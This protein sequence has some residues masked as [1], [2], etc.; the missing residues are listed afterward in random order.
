MF[1]SC[2]DEASRFVRLLA[3][4]GRMD[5]EFEDLVPLVQD[6]VD[7]HPG[8]TF[9]QDAPEFHSRYIHTVSY[10]WRFSNIY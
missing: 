2:H 9:L 3:K 5:L 10:T 6:V 8:L 7:N 4:P 1:T